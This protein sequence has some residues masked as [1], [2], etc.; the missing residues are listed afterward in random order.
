MDDWWND[1]TIQ[2]FNALTEGDARQA[3]YRCC[4]STR[5]TEN[6]LDKR[7]FSSKE[8]LF[9]AAEEIWWSLSSEDWLEAFKGHPKIG[10][11]S[12]LRKKYN[13]SR[14]WSE[15]EQEGVEGAGEETLEAL[16][17]GNDAYLE[18]YGFIFIVCATG[19]SAEEMLSL[20]QVRLKNS[21][22]EELKI[23]A[24]EQAKITA[25]RLEKLIKELNSPFSKNAPGTQEEK[26]MKSPI[27]THV[28]DTAKGRPAQGITV[29]LE[30]RDKTGAWAELARGVTNDDGRITDWLSPGEPAEEGIYRVTFHVA[31][32]F[33]ESTPFYSSIPVIFHLDEPESH[34]HIPLLLSPFGYSTYRGS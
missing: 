20:L 24:Q 18:K 13:Q 22:D 26:T 3:L 9:E 6:L 12:S 10:D 7:P 33:D 27:T 28:L 23:A 25:L 16:S 31:D 17:R 29:V 32:Y 15:G 1:M 21:R 4:S 14:A 2:K 5:F 11:I 30:L 19:K 34:Y 8:E